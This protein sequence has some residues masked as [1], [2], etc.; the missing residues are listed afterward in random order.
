MKAFLVYLF[1]LSVLLFHTAF[2]QPIEQKLTAFDG[3]AFQQFGISVSIDNM[4]A[5]V[6]ANMDDDNGANSGSL[7]I[8]ENVAGFLV[9]ESKQI[10]DDGAE[11]DWFGVS[12]DID[13]I[14]AIVGASGK[15]VNTGAA[16]IFFRDQGPG[17]IQ[18][19]RLIPANLNSA[20]FF[21][22][23]VSIIGDYA[24]VG[25][26]GDDENGPSSGAAYIFKRNGS[27]WTQQAKLMASDAEAND[28]FGTSVSI[29]DEFTFVGAPFED[30]NGTNAGAVYVFERNDTVWNQ[31][32]KLLSSDGVG[33]DHFGISVNAEDN[34]L[35]AGG[36]DH[37]TNTVQ[38][39]AAYIFTIAD[40]SWSEQDK[41]IA[42]DGTLTEAFGGSVW[43]SGNYAIVGSNYNDVNGS[44]SGAVYLY[45][46]NGTDWIEH[47]KILASD[48]ADGDQFGRSVSIE[49]DIVLVGSV[50]DDDNG[51]NSGSVYAYTDFVSGIEEVLPG[52][53]NSFNLNQNYP[54]P[55]NPTTKIRFEIPERSFILLKVYDVLG[56]E[57]GTLVDKELS[58]GE[59]NMDFDATG[60][61][62][63]IYFYSLISENFTETK[64]MIL[65][66]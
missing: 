5:V 25:A 51:Q 10:A 18:Q 58:S 6:G 28:W 12:V 37:I 33:D 54:N 34:Y 63:G 31:K 7:Y 45:K 3:G 52:I 16:Y 61:S 60:L 17:W 49:G 23:S 56:N 14:T 26:N 40:T 39:G 47:M 65:L 43:I 36:Y 20:A 55:F 57:V 32:Q 4:Y 8:Y 13:S 44:N 9:L 15:D 30:E 66:R 1:S 11:N 29:T 27:S 48:G 41:L 21:G 2:A 50:G 46:K 35:I 38:K 24:I 22:T 62:S 53:P 42:S 64:K 59:Y 19:Q